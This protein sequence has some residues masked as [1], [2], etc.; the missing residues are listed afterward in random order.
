MMTDIPFPHRDPRLPKQDLLLTIPLPDN[1]IDGYAE[2]VFNLCDH[3]DLDDI[4]D[5]IMDDDWNDE[6]DLDLLIS[7]RTVQ[8]IRRERH[9]PQK[10]DFTWPFTQETWKEFGQK[11]YIPQC[12]PQS[13]TPPPHVDRKRRNLAARLLER[14]CRERVFLNKSESARH[15][16]DWRKQWRNTDPKPKF[17]SMVEFWEA[18]PD[19]EEPPETD[20]WYDDPVL[21]AIKSWLACQHDAH[22][23][24]CH[25]MAVCY[26]DAVW[27]ILDRCHHFLRT[28]LEFP[29]VEP[30]FEKMKPLMLQND[31][32]KQKWASV[33]WPPDG[34]IWAD[35]R[36][37]YAGYADCSPNP[38]MARQERYWPLEGDDVWPFPPD[39]DPQYVRDLVKR[40]VGNDLI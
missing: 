32:Y 4:L 6:Y 18:W 2:P 33:T 31:A 19:W 35:S 27:P 17:I 15:G 28:D 3:E 8:S 7:P 22:K 21:S 38:W 36:K 25:T 37:K 5:D 10:E 16:P 14:A 34:R 13:K 39:T 1:I 23:P 20:S 11:K 29:A 24:F 12:N 26:E 9:W 40:H 30:A